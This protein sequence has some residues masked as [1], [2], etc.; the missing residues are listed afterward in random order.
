MTKGKRVGNN[1]PY[2][3]DPLFSVSGK[4]ALVTGAN[5]LLGTVIVNTLR[6]Y[7]AEVIGVYR[8]E[9]RKPD[10]ARTLRFDMYEKGGYEKLWDFAK[11]NPV[12]ILI[13][14]AH[15]MSE[16]TGFNIQE[17]ALENYDAWTWWRKEIG[18]LSFPASTISA[19]GA[20][21]KQRGHGNIINVCTMYSLVAPSPALYNNTVYMNP[22][23]YSAVK[24]GLLALTRYVA[25]FWG[26]YG[27]RCNAILPGPFPKSQSDQSF[28]KRLSDR[29]CLGRV[30]KPEELAGPVI[31]LASEASSYMTGQALIYDGGWTSL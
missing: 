24:A 5:G 4:V 19:F 22:P 23:A 12:D 10:L 17:D 6:E 11:E 29:T 2:L 7:G 27:I 8:N 13:N 31:F 28:M 3:I 30:G 26:K 16:K 15:E 18:G 25:S 14:N 20:G 1:K 9:E 21:M